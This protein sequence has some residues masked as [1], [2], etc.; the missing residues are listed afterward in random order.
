MAMGL[1]NTFR[2]PHLHMGC[3]CL[4]M[5]CHHLSKE[6]FQHPTSMKKKSKVLIFLM[7]KFG[8][9]GHIVCLPSC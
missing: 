2:P 4:D 8:K 3:Q 1:M 6:G 9:I 5:V 7:R